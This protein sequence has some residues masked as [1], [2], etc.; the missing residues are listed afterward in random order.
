M[1]D[2]GI[3][4]SSLQYVTPAHGG[5]GVVRVG[6]LAPESYQLFVCPFACGRH[7][8]LGAIK[9]GLKDRI[10]Y[11]YIDQSDIISGYDDLILEGVDE[12]LG[13]L[14]KRP[15]VLFVFVSCLDDLIGTDCDAVEQELGR[16]NP[17]IQFRLAHMNPIT[18]GSDEPPQVGIQKRIYSL[19]AKQPRQ[20][21]GI[22]TIGNLV[23]VADGCELHKMLKLE[24]GQVLRHISEYSGFDEWQDMA[25]SSGNIVLMPSGVRAA[26]DMQERCGIPYIFL[27]VSYDLEVIAGQY[28]S[29]HEFINSRVCAAYDFSSDIAGAQ[30]AIESALKRIGDFPIFI[31][32][33]AV[34]CP[35]GLAK[36]LNKYGF[37]VRRVFVQEVIPADREAF[38]WVRAN[39]PD[40]EVIQPQHYDTVNFDRRFEKS[41]AIGFNA[42]YISGS[43]H[44]VNAVADEGMFGYY[45][46][47]EL[48]HMME[49]AMDTAADLC[50]LI[51]DYGMVV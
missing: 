42:A 5:W 27:P 46:V 33:S 15:R 12:L 23:A 30:A 43:R 32:D 47:K 35:F 18:M 48:M 3:F 19:L 28:L 16:R 49:A 21:N 13:Q 38:E 51:E 29:I 4:S 24:G 36:A 9:H 14:D 6:M 39:M 45:G 11:F 8:A 34:I 22:N 40:T 17:D 2:C 7:G 50:A 20:D 37:C 10:S 26:R 31:D 44:I 41:L 1:C 25:R